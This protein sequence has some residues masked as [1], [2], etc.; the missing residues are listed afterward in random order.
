MLLCLRPPP[1]SPSTN[2]TTEWCS[3]TP[4]DGG[5]E[6][7]NKNIRKL[8][9]RYLFKYLPTAA[10]AR[11]RIKTKASFHSVFFC[12]S[13]DTAYTYNCLVFAS[14]SLRESLLVW[15][16][17]SVV[18]GLFQKFCAKKV[19]NAFVCFMITNFK[20]NFWMAN[21]SIF[22]IWPNHML[23]SKSYN[24]SR[25]SQLHEAFDIARS[26]MELF[27]L[28]AVWGV[29]FNTTRCDSK[30]YLMWSLK[31]FNFFFRMFV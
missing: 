23:L 12:C 21:F 16:S 22:F 11:C 31:H 17:P 15:K 3:H 20:L 26:L 7:Q 5:K 25:R 13:T 29:G 1:P 2:T 8:Y 28:F 9:R 27:N 14:F 24:R 18:G 19:R 30:D 10:E 4:K 6:T